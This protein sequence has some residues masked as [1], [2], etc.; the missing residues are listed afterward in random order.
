MEYAKDLEDREHLVELTLPVPSRIP[1]AY[2][3]HS[4]VGPNGCYIVF[5]GTYQERDKIH[6]AADLLDIT[7]SEFIRRLANDAADTV[8]AYYES[9][10]KE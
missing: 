10:N 1:I 2:G 5:R 4:T 8:I 7:L 3:L 6:Y 9:N